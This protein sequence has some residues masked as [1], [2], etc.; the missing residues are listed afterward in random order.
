MR[1]VGNFFA[2]AAAMGLAACAPGDPGNGGNNGDDDSASHPDADPNAGFIDAAPFIDAGGFYDG[3]GQQNG[4][5]DKIDILFVVDNSGSMEEEQANLATNFPAF[6]DVIENYT[7][8][9]GDHLDYHLAIT[10]TD[11]NFTE[12]DMIPGIPIPF[13]SPHFGNDGKF[14]VGNNCGF[15]GGRRFLQK[16]DANVRAAFSCAAKVGTDGDSSEM[17][18]EATKLA[19][20]DRIQDGYNSGFLRE[21]ALLAVVM[22]T[23]ENDCS[24]SGDPVDVTSLDICL[25]A[26]PVE[27]YLAALDALKGGERGRWAAAVIA[28]P[29]PGTCESTFGSAEEATR[30][31][32]FTTAVGQNAVFSSICAGDLATSLHDAFETFGIAC[33]N[34]PPVN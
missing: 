21:D 9:G 10:T 3:G 27:Q 1:H 18:L 14:Q 17:P 16:G 24:V 6:V 13:P 5:C 19:L 25:Q 8:S 32:Q 23:D 11:R 28:G 31:K 2:L 29:G 12:N 22:L 33:E 20:L 15:P 7:T 4:A 34:I 26:N 30:L